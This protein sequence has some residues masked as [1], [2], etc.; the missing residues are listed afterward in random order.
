[1][2][3]NEKQPMVPPRP[4]EIRE[5]VEYEENARFF[6]MKP[7]VQPPQGPKPWKEC[8][9]LGGAAYIE[10]YADGQVRTGVHPEDA[11]QPS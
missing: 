5:A 2:R 9:L 7:A 10:I 11:E 6:A 8:Y 1:M 4:A 3:R